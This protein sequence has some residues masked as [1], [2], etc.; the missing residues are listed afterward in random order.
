METLPGAL[1]ALAA[2]AQFVTWYAYPSATRPGKTDKVPTL[3]HSGAPCNAHDAANWTDAATA[4]ATQHLADRGYGSGVGFVF[5]DADPFF[6]ADVDGAHD[7]SAWSPLA[8]ELVARFPGAAVEVS[9]SGRG[10]HII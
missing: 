6:C 10:L 7:G 9:H 2:S 1:A 8:L 4:I 3:W 5:T